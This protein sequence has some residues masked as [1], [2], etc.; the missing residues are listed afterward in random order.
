MN[1]V[2]QKRQIETIEVDPFDSKDYQK[3]ILNKIMENSKTTK[4][5]LYLH[6]I[7]PTNKYYKRIAKV[8]I[9]KKSKSIVIEYI[10]DSV[11]FDVLDSL[12]FKVVDYH[13]IGGLEYYYMRK[14]KS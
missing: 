4:V 10:S 6:Y 1:K 3:E 7:K 2:T 13:N 14:S 9:Q 12:N 5:I 8:I 11:V